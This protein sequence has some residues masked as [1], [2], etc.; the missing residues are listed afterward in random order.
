MIDVS[1]RDRAVK[2]RF[3]LQVAQTRFHLLLRCD[4]NRDVRFGSIKIRLRLH[5]TR[6]GRH[7]SRFCRGDFD[8]YRSGCGNRRLELRFR[9]F[10]EICARGL[11]FNKVAK[12]LGF[13]L[14]GVDERLFLDFLRQRLIDARSDTR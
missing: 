14:A 11:F 8:V 9:L 3:D 6:F 2:G 1:L 12:S 7:H 10:Q 13:C 4:G 5:D